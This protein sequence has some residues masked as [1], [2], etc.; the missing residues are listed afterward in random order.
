MR[1]LA[2]IVLLASID[3]SRS[4]RIHEERV[5]MVYPNRI[6]GEEAQLIRQEV[7]HVYVY[8]IKI[9]LHYISNAYRDITLFRWSPNGQHFFF[10]T[11][12]KNQYLVVQDRQ[13]HYRY[14]DFI[15]QIQWSKTSDKL[16]Y[17]GIVNPGQEK[18]RLIVI[19][20]GVP[21]KTFK[22]VNNLFFDEQNKLCAEGEEATSIH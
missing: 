5:V 18:E 11:E 2:L 4:P 9:G 21:I 14:F 19:L 8:R 10:I 1:I 20:N 17:F 13:E 3:P 6:T 16:A 12:D 22:T 7:G 15:G